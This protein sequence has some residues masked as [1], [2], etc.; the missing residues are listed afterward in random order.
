[1]TAGRF[2][3]ADLRTGLIQEFPWRLPAD[4][5]VIPIP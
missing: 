2:A 1:M 3:I 4:L 5:E